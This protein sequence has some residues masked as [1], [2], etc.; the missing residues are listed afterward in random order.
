MRR[1][2]P[3]AML[4]RRNVLRGAGVCLALPWLESLAPKSA[5]AQAPGMPRRYLP[6]TFPCGAAAAWWQHAPAFG[7]GVFGDDFLLSQVHEPLAPVKDKLLV[8]SRVANNSWAGATERDFV[9]PSHSRL[10][11]ALGTCRDTDRLTVEAG[12]SY[13]TDAVNDVSADQVIARGLAG[14]TLQLGLGTYPGAFDGRSWAYSQS[15]SWSGPREPLKRQVNPKAVFDRFGIVWPD[16]DPLRRAAENASVIDAVLKDASTLRPRLSRL[17]QQAVDRF[18]ESFRDLEQ[19]VKQVGT[20]PSC[21]RIQRIAQLA[22][23]PDAPGPGQGLNQ[24]DQGYDRAEHAKLMNDIIAL[25]LQCDMTRVISYMLDD[26]RSDFDYSFI[27]ETERVFGP[28][29]GLDTYH[30]GCHGGLGSVDAVP[31]NG[32][33]PGVNNAAYATV[34]RWWMRQVADVAKKLAD[35][36]EGDGSV[37]DHTLIHVMSEMRTHDSRPWDLPMLLIGGT[38]VIKQNGHIALSAHPAD[39]QLRD[40]YFTIQRQYFGLDVP[41]FGEGPEPSALIWEILA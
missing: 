38:G 35:V 15:Y 8:L 36:P 6:I 29:S 37:L 14:L 11:A 30:G 32:V 5:A 23:I 25:A 17:D 34:N 7:T 28:V 22:E 9:A 24:G 18:L 3:K 1:Y 33:Y 31:V 12:L 10:S 41:S 16:E 39:R 40:V 21:Q 20:L 13:V 26:S 4:S 27:P 2:Q 19:R